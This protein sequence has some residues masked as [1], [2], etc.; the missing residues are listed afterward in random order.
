MQTL[1]EV[2]T[3]AAAGRIFEAMNT[4][5]VSLL[6]PHLSDD[7]RFDFPGA[8]VI[9][10]KKRVLVFLKA[11]LRKYPDIEFIV[12]DVIESPGKICIVWTNSARLE[13]PRPYRNSGVT[14]V[15]SVDGRITWISD[16]FKD[17]SF[18]NPAAAGPL[19]PA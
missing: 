9:A 14:V 5:N 1:S 13:T 15:Y 8:G 12:Q 6:E 2:S 4:K 3:P 18:V 11:L 16:Y 17:T 10:G 19:P 7:V